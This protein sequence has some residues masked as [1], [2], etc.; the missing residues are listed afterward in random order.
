MQA[1][2]SEYW[3]REA[4]VPSM[5]L[6]VWPPA[7]E[8]RGHVRHVTPPGAGEY[9]PAGHWVQLKVQSPATG[10]NVPTGHKMQPLLGL[11]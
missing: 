8:Y 3:P 5:H 10:L 4:E 2:T 9:V 11:P 1:T 7:A 6:H